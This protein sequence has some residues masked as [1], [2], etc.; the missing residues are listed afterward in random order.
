M[1]KFTVSSD[2]LKPA[3]KKL[4]LAVNPNSVVESAKSIY[5]EVSK[6]QVRMIAT[7]MEVVIAVAMAVE[8][9]D[10]EDFSI[11]VPFGFFNKVISACPSA[12]VVI[13]HPS[14]R[15]A[16]ILCSGDVFEISSLPKPEEFPK[17][18]AVPKKAMHLLNQTFIGYLGKALHTTSKDN[19]RPAMTRVVLD[20]KPGASYVA[21]TDAHV[22]YRQKI[23][24]EATEACQL[25]FSGKV[26]KAMEGLESVEL[27]WTEKKICVKSDTVT[28]W[29]TRYE[30]KYPDYNLVIPSYGPNLSVRKGDLSAALHKCLIID[31]STR[32]ADIAPEAKSIQLSSNDPD[33]GLNISVAVEGEYTGE[34]KKFA[35]NAKKMLTVLDQ[36]DA[37]DIHLHVHSPT[38]AVL[39][40]APDEPD[41]LGLVMPLIINQ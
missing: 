27:S 36:L 9:G 40:S 18:P 20:I 22:M 21:S 30:D 34:V 14:A 1:K 11:L 38:K 3:L 17:L 37:E 10:S 19:L 6:N 25:Q 13:E 8:T 35:V 24:L 33:R 39:V 7:D 31:I 5:C 26:I 32:Q 29:C 2:I 23:N 12:P 4:S 41:F 15:K 28:I 16:R